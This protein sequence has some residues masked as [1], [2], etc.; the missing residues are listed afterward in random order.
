PRGSPNSTSPRIAMTAKDLDAF[1]MTPPLV[2]KSAAPALRSSLAAAATTSSW[3][4]A[5][6][7]CM[8]EAYSP[9]MPSTQ[10]A[11]APARSPPTWA[12]LE[13]PEFTKPSRIVRAIAEA[14][15][16]DQPPP[17]AGGNPRAPDR[18][19]GG[20]VRQVAPA[21]DPEVGP[22]LPD[23]DQVDGDQHRE[24]ANGERA[25]PDEPHQGTSI[26]KPGA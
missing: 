6:R 3:R 7:R 10:P 8:D 21:R 12:E 23:L 25:A 19:P 1:N 17:L 15:G 18:A 22:A 9:D 5:R 13:M 26:Q 20:D 2:L 11:P 16:S 24:Q 14:T 4:R